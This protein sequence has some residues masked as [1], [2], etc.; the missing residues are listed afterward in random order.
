LLQPPLEIVDR[1]KDDPNI[2]SERVLPALATQ[3]NE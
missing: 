1:Y 2:Y 3:N